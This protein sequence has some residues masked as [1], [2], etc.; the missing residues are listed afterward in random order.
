MSH[1][2][3]CPYLGD[4]RLCTTS[5]GLFGRCS[6]DV[7]HRPLEIQYCCNL[8]EPAIIVANI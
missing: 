5:V 3:S 1:D 2:K 4:F 6:F 8:P 7:R